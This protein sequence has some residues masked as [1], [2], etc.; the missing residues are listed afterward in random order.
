LVLK[1]TTFWLIVNLKEQAKSTKISYPRRHQCS[2]WFPWECQLSNELTGYTYLATFSNVNRNQIS[3]VSKVTW[4]Q[5]QFS[6]LA[7]NN[8]LLS[9]WIKGL[10][11]LPYKEPSTTNKPSPTISRNVHTNSSIAWNKNIYDIKLYVCSCLTYFWQNWE[12][13]I[14]SNFSVSKPKTKTK[15]CGLSPWAHYTDRAT[16]AC[17]LSQIEGVAQ[18]ALQISTAVFSDF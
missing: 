18:S 15:L 16:A 12:K 2:F 17:Q 6:T 14:S 10:L 4:W 1:H 9:P 13:Y 11:A 8:M 7:T 3:P 5:G